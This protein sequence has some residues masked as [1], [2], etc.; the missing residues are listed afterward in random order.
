MELAAASGR[1]HLISLPQSWFSLDAVALAPKL[2][3]HLLVH[4][5]DEGLTVGR[6]V[7]T[8]AYLGTRDEASHSFRGESLR[9]RSMFRRGGIA[10]VYV[11]YGMHHCV[12]VVS[13][14]E[15][16][17][18]AVLIRALEPLAGVA[19]MRRRRKIKDER[20]LSSGPGKLCQAMGIDRSHDGLSLRDSELRLCRGKTVTA[21]Q[22]ATGPRVG[23]TKDIDHPWRFWI[24]DNA[25]VSRAPKSPR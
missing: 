18:E 19:L 16:V 20:A 5:S 17:G 23:I 7:E 11:I 4:D 6:I 22:I 24:R 12:N 25:F 3:G 2:L 1:S 14:P 21:A 15:G 9:N 8:E 13:G 10:Y